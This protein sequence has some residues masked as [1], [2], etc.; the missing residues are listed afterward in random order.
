MP[1]EVTHLVPALD[2]YELETGLVETEGTGSAACGARARTGR[3]CRQPLVPG[4]AFCRY[5]GCRPANEQTNIVARSSL[6][7]WGRAVTINGRLFDA[8]DLRQA[9]KEATKLQPSCD[10]K[11]IGMIALAF[12]EAVV[13][14]LQGFGRRSPPAEIR[15][16]AERVGR[17]AQALLD[18]FGMKAAPDR[19]VPQQITYLLGDALP[20]LEEDDAAARLRE[21]GVDDEADLFR[22][23][24]AS[25]AAFGVAGFGRYTDEDMADLTE[26]ERKALAGRDDT[27]A[28]RVAGHG[29]Q[30]IQKAI[31]AVRFLALLANRTVV[32]SSGGPDGEREENQHLDDLV[33]AISRAYGS[34]TGEDTPTFTQAFKRF[35]KT[36]MQLLIDRGGAL[37]ASNRRA[38]WRLFPSASHESAVRSLLDL[39]TSDAALRYRFEKV[40]ARQSEDRSGRG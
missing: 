35:A 25:E 11:A 39:R 20:K 24:M 22:I 4:K 16:W 23:R 33:R 5:H 14:C 13:E 19:A 17:A 6:P 21:Q 38:R 8:A 40:R 2:I 31:Q 9:I 1:V 3:P 32:L 18:C 34:L 37:P 26:E 28:G 15:E 10:D 27:D 29:D 12:D 7:R 36:A 30:E